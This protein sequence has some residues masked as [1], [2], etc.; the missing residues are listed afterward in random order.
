[1][2]QW[3]WSWCTIALVLL[4]LV[5]IFAFITVSRP[6]DHLAAWLFFVPYAARVAFTLVLNT[7]IFALKLFQLRRGKPRKGAF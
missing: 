4:L 6:Q 1:M 3:V 2:I 5:V 7:S